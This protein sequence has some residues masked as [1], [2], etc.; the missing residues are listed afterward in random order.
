MNEGSDMDSQ[1]L[2]ASSPYFC[3][4]SGSVRPIEPTVGCLESGEEFKI[5]A[6][7]PKSETS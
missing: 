6:I 4:A 2:T 5:K 7:E 1:T 3:R